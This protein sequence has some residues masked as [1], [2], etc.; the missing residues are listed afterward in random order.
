[1][2]INMKGAEDS[3]KNIEQTGKYVSLE[4]FSS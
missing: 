4:N 2:L 1:M 3:H